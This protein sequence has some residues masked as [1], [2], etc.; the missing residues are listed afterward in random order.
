MS[1]GPGRPAPCP[2]STLPPL[3][4]RTRSAGALVF[5]GLQLHYLSAGNKLLK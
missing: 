2:A 3:P 5:T 4:S 1:G